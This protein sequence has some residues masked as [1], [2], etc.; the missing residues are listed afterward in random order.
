MTMVSGDGMAVRERRERAPRMGRTTTG[1]SSREGVR[2]VMAGVLVGGMLA[3]VSGCS[4]HVART[5]KLAPDGRGAGG[6]SYFLPM[7]HALVSFDRVRADSK[8][9]EAV[10]KATEAKTEAEAKLKAAIAAEA[11]Q[12]TLVDTLRS[13][14][15]DAASEAFKTQQAELVRRGL[16]VVALKAALAAADS[17]LA[18][19]E[20][21]LR[22]FREADAM[23]GWVDAIK[24]E[25]QAPV[26]DTR[27]RYQLNL[28]D[29]PFRHDVFKIGTTTSGLLKTMDATIEDQSAE[30]V[31]SLAQSLASRSAKATPST[32]AWIEQ[33]PLR[34]KPDCGKQAWRPVSLKLLVDPVKSDEWARASRLIGEAAKVEALTGG[35]ER[36]FDYVFYFAGDV[37][38]VAPPEPGPTPA[39]G[40]S[41]R[42]REDRV[43]RQE[44]GRWDGIFYRRERPLLVE[45]WLDRSPVGA[46]ALVVPN[47]APVDAAHVLATSFATNVTKVGFENGMLVS[48]DSDRP[49][50]VLEVVSLPWKVAKATVGIIAEIFQL[51]VNVATSQANLMAQQVTLIE[52]M[53]ALIEAERALEATR[54]GDAPPET[55][56]EVPEG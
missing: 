38:D 13:S 17:K 18:S 26:P 28:E 47:G 54:A 16:E 51:R 15:F 24:V 56:D 3:A 25:L 8:A 46:F 20:L 12:K 10:T 43:A 22:N 53:E 39:R 35:S 19:A 5:S 44:S 2:I 30:I 21:A 23:C 55:L 34:S 45:V 7:R 50:P 4:T 40:T 41:R 11:A 29:S 33:A 14:G 27:V 31:I 52:K 42:T 6:V 49:S 32:L 36:T 48:F 1:V 37:A 9:A